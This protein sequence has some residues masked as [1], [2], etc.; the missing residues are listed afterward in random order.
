MSPTAAPAMSAQ[1]DYLAHIEA[2]QAG[3]C[4]E[5]RELAAAADVESGRR[6]GWP[7]DERGA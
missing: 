5:C 4:A 6:L 7:A 3:W 2:C 1:A